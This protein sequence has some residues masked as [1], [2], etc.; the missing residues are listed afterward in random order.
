MS[1]KL[2]FPEKHKQNFLFFFHQCHRPPK[3][4]DFHQFHNLHF[5][6]VFCCKVINWDFFKKSLG[7]GGVCDIGGKKNRH[8]FFWYFS[9]NITRSFI[10]D[11]IFSKKNTFFSHFIGNFVV[12]HWLIK[13]KILVFSS[14]SWF[15][16]LLYWQ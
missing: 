4:Q 12:K 15:Y 10:E 8:L 2:I 3:F 16:D 6:S 5:F 1:K 9:K 11:F 7:V 14:F 13:L